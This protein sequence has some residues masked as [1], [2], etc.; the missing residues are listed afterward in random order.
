M[1]K[2]FPHL[3]VPTLALK[4]PTGHNKSSHRGGQRQLY[5]RIFLEK[6][7]KNNDSDRQGGPAP[8]EYL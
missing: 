3:N 4:A 5:K 2:V 8:P 7:N 1:L 6:K